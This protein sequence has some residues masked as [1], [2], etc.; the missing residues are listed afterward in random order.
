MSWQYCGKTAYLI[1]EREQ[2]IYELVGTAM[3]VWKTI[4]YNFPLDE[5]P[6]FVCDYYR[7]E[8]EEYQKI[9]DEVYSFIERLIH[10]GFLEK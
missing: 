10:N 7:I 9:N 2:K 1:D 6:K 4:E 8:P 5:I 3:V